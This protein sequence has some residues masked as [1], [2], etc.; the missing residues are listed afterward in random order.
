LVIGIAG[1]HTRPWLVLGLQHADGQLHHLGRLRGCHL[2]VTKGM[3]QKEGKCRESEAELN[4]VR[5]VWIVGEE[6]VR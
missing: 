2:Y 4:V 1:D 3:S 6:I 5:G